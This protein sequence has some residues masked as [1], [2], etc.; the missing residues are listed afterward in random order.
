MQFAIAEIIADKSLLIKTVRDM[1]RKGKTGQLKKLFVALDRDFCDNHQI[2][3]QPYHGE[4]WKR[5]D[6]N[7]WNE[8]MRVLFWRHKLPEDVDFV[9]ADGKTISWELFQEVAKT[10][11]FDSGFGGHRI[12]LGVK[13]VGNDWWL[14]RVEYDGAE[15]WRYCTMPTR[16]VE[17]ATSAKMVRKLLL[18]DW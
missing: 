9:T 4:E 17:K 7:L 5:P 18:A 3:L 14:E 12:D 6:T 11:E 8:T 13:I 16:K 2:P 15:S 1:R 10:I